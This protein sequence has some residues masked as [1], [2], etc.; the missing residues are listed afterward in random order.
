MLLANV[1][2]TSA[3]LGET[4]SRRAK[5]D[6]LARLLRQLGTEEIEPAVAWLAGAP[7]QGKVGT[8]WRTL[9]AA[10]GEPAT[11]ATLTVGDVDH[12]LTE[13]IGASGAGSVARR[14]AVLGSLF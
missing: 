13:L 14:R 6:I 5:I 1:V 4:R 8:G 11:A 9:V 7:R 2:A 3:E 12:G 10:R